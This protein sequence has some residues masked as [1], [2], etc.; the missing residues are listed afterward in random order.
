[1]DNGS[2]LQEGVTLARAGAGALSVGLTGAMLLF[3]RA[4]HPPTGAT[5]LIVSLG[6]LQ[7]AREMAMLMV[8]VVILTV[9]GWAIN[10]ALGVPMPSW[11]AKE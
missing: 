7:T 1:M 3:L 9:A 4:S 6:F 2:V 10:R 8:G 11:S 5:T